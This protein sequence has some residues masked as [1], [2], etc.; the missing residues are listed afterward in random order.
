MHVR[1]VSILIPRQTTL[2]EMMTNSSRGFTLVNP[3]TRKHAG[4]FHIAAIKEMQVQCIHSTYAY[5]SA[6]FVFSASQMPMQREHKQLQTKGK[7]KPYYNDHSYA[8]LLDLSLFF[9]SL[10]S[11]FSRNSLSLC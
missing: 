5:I 6:R 9:S 10:P 7:Y 3:K 8:P 4:I 2:Q 11:A 1:S